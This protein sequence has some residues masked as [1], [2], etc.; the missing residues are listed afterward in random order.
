MI[1][2]TK[3]CSWLGHAAVAITARYAMRFR[4][5][6]MTIAARNGSMPDHVALILAMRAPRE[7]LKAVVD[8]NAVQMPG[9]VPFWSRTC[10]RF[11]N[12][13]VHQSMATVAA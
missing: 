13:M 5:R 1:V 9:L 8:S 12:E 7:I 2:T 6:R 4:A 10:E 11:E 3:K